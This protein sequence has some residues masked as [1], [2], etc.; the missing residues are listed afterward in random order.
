MVKGGGALFLC[1]KGYVI[2]GKFRC[3][4][5]TWVLLS[6]V[7][8]FESAVLCHTDVR[9][10]TEKFWCPVIC[11]IGWAGGSICSTSGCCL[12]IANKVK[13]RGLWAELLKP[14][15]LATKRVPLTLDGSLATESFIVIFSF[16]V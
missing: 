7:T 1:G 6:S 10:D 9:H 16:I 5:Q 4:G 8:P 15:W 2:H 12:V 3:C 14:V 11:E 13:L